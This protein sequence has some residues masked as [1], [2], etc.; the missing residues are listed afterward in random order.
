MSSKM[1]KL[2]R[3]YSYEDSAHKS[4]Q[5]NKTNEWQIVSRADIW[6]CCSSGFLPFDRNTGDLV[7]TSI[8][9]FTGRLRVCTSLK[10]QQPFRLWKLNWNDLINKLYLW[11]LHFV[12]WMHIIMKSTKPNLFVFLWTEWNLF[13]WSIC[14]YAILS[15]ISLKPKIVF[16]FFLLVVCLCHFKSKA[17]KGAILNGIRL[18]VHQFNSI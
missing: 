16:L 5:A 6:V 18:F 3:R 12:D 17:K 7:E 10:S 1:H 9:Y 4:M 14:Q 11:P 2:F 13:K 8:A 15:E